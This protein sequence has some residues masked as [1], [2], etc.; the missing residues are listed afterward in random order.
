MRVS[1][2][3]LIACKAIIKEERNEYK[4]NSVCQEES[5]TLTRSDDDVVDRDEDELHEEANEPHDHEPD[6]RTD[7]HLCELCCIQIEK[8]KSHGKD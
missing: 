5:L 2:A 7:R 4:F 1:I 6:S 3:K 8:R